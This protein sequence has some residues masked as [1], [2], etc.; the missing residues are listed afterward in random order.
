[1]QVRVVTMFPLSLTFYAMFSNTLLAATN[2]LLGVFGLAIVGGAFVGFCVGIVVETSGFRAGIG[3]R[4]GNFFFVSGFFL[5][6]LL[7]TV[8]PKSL[9]SISLYFPSICANS[10]QHFGFLLA[11]SRL[12]GFWGDFLGGS[13]GTNFSDFQ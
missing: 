3:L 4:V 10:F 11:F 2:F 12:G 7:V 13:A 8:K 9:T 5:L 1:M 6:P